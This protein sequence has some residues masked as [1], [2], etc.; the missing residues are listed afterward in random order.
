MNSKLSLVVF[1][2]ATATAGC[3]QRG[4]QVSQD[5]EATL[6][7]DVADMAALS[8]DLA[9]S[10]DGVENAALTSSACYPTFGECSWCFDFEGTRAAGTF[11]GAPEMTPCGAQVEGERGT[12]SYQLQ[13]GELNGSWTSAGAGYTVSVS[14]HRIASLSITRGDTTRERHAE[15]DL[16]S[17]VAT[18]ESGEVKSWDVQFTYQGFAGR[19]WVVDLTSDGS[20]LSGTVEGERFSCVIGGVPGAPTADC[21]PN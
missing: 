16:E 3:V 10:A 13:E 17:L 21:A 4:D 20:T 2:S 7:N 9:E 14:G 5:L 1:L 12:I 6:V 8:L 18:V 15:I 11:S 19:T